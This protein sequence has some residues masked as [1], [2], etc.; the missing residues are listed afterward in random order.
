MVLFSVSIVVGLIAVGFD[1]SRVILVARVSHGEQIT[2][3][4]AEASD[5]L[6]HNLS[7]I[8]AGL[9]VVTGVVFLA[10]LYRAYKNLDAFGAEALTSSPGSALISFFVPMLNLYLP[11]VAVSELWKASDPA[12]A[13]GEAWQQTRRSRLVIVWWLVLLAWGIARVIESFWGLRFVPFGRVTSDYYMRLA[14]IAVVLDVFFI[15]SAMLSLLLVYR[16][17]RRQEMKAQSGQ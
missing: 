12:S 4:E 5:A 15:V 13:A 14:Q 2:R 9:Y 10:W 3:N 8:Q 1:V 7:L 6:Q 17:N 11:A 16:I